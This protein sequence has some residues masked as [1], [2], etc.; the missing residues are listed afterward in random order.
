MF[1]LFYPLF[2]Q[3]ILPTKLAFMT[4]DLRNGRISAGSHFPLFVMLL[5]ALYDTTSFRWCL[6]R[7]VFY[8]A[9]ARA[10]LI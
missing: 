9:S 7:E 2:S 6:W 10:V 1:H 8:I 5:R 3:H 4:R